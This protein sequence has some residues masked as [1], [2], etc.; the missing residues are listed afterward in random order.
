[1]GS[2]AR[3]P[4]PQQDYRPLPSRRRTLLLTSPAR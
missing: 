4:R 1:V 2:E 3:D